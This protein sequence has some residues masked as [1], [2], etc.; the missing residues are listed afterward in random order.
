MRFI[1]AS[2][3]VLVLTACT[4]AAPPAD[5]SRAVGLSL[6]EATALVEAFEAKQVPPSKRPAPPTTME[7][8]LG[9][10]KSDRLDLFPGA[11][12]FLSTQTTPEATALKAQTL[13]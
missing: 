13:L 10:L 5:R 4:T 7:E 8:A 2:F 12:S 11:V 1:N 3:V 9:V 6:R